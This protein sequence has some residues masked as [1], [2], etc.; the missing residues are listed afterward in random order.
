[1]S[2]ERPPLILTQKHSTGAPDLVVEIASPSTRKRD[3]TIQLLLY[4]RS[5]VAEYRLWIPSETDAGDRNLD[6][7]FELSA[8]FRA[9][10]SDVLWPSHP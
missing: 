6:G 2:R 9:D 4:E 3:A 1:M 7:K 8:Q 5:G 10:A